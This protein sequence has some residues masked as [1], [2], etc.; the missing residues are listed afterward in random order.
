MESTLV[1][2]PHDPHDLPGRVTWLIGLIVYMPQASVHIPSYEAGL[3]SDQ[4]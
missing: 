3:W 4:V 1:M 2:K